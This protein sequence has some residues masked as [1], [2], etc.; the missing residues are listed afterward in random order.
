[1][2]ALCPSSHERSP[3]YSASHTQVLA[4]ASSPV[5]LKCLDL[6]VTSWCPTHVAP[7]EGGQPSWAS[8]KAGQ[9]RFDVAAADLLEECHCGGCQEL[10]AKPVVVAKCRKECGPAS[11][12]PL[13]HAT[14]PTLPEPVCTRAP[15]RVHSARGR[16]ALVETPGA[17]GLGPVP[18]GGEHTPAETCRVTQGGVGGMQPGVDQGGGR[19]PERVWAKAEMLESGTEEP[20]AGGPVSPKG[21]RGSGLGSHRTAQGQAG[22][23]AWSRRAHL[24]LTRACQHSDPHSPAGGRGPRSPACPAHLRPRGPGDAQACV[25]GRGQS[26]KSR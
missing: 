2:T 16:Q 9:K 25:P 22:R 13:P 15:R 17:G 4:T 26:Q 5:S 6:E 19:C 18:T 23:A 7:G 1:M 20:R 3:C 12:P 11:R 24:Y 21:S 14:A 10:G 8:A